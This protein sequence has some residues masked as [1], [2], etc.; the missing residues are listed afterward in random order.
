MFTL[1]AVAIQIVGTFMLFLMF[2][3]ANKMSYESRVALIDL[4]YSL[5]IYDL[6]KKEDA[7]EKT[8]DNLKNFQQLCIARVK[9][10][11]I[12]DKQYSIFSGLKFS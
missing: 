1:L 3:Q 4:Y 9:A 10:K 8:E 12:I 11:T 5:E 6:E 7:L 2:S